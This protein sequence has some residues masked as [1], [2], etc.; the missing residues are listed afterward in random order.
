MESKQDILEHFAD[1]LTVI[2]HPLVSHKLS[3][4]RDKETPSNIFRDAVHELA[5]LEAYEATR[6]LPTLEVQVETPIAVT[7]CRT[8][9]G[10]EPVIVPILRAGLAMQDAFTTLI[11]TAP[12]AH[13]G[14]YRNEET[15][16]PIEYYAKMPSDIA[17]RPVLV[18]D[19]ML[20]TGGSLAAAIRSLRKRG[21]ADITC[22]VMVATPEGIKR[23][24]EFDPNVR[25][26]TA[27]LDDGLND[28]AYIVPGLGDAGDRIFQTLNTAVES[29]IS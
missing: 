9:K 28:D 6:T 20:A 2:D 12:V 10:R 26:I 27:A 3:V 25:I 19:P 17:E 24:L 5:M 21:V 1:R 13:L 23:V 11:P 7:T 4:I 14:M 22:V 18:V 29:D 15:H 16:E 8:I